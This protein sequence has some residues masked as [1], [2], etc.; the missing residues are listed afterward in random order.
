[1]EVYA[2]SL[3]VRSA[4]NE[5]LAAMVDYHVRRRRG[6]IRFAYP[7]VVLDKT[8]AAAR[9]I[10]LLLAGP[11]CQGHSNLNNHT[12]RNDPRNDLYVTTAATAVA[13]AARGV[14]IENVATV[15][16]SHGDVVEIARELLLQ[17]GYG[18]ADGRLKLSDLGG[19]QTRERYFMIAVGGVSSENLQK[20]FDRWVEAHRREAL[21]V[22]WAID[23]LEEIAN[24]TLDTN[25]NSSPQPKKETRRRIDWLFDNEAHDLA[26]A[27]R[28]DCHKEGTTYTAVYG[29]MHEKKPAPTITTGIGTPGQGRFIHPRARRLITP[30][31]A[32][33]IQTFPDWW[34]FETES[35]RP[36][37]TALAKWIGDA[38][39]PM[40]GIHPITVALS[41]ILNEKPKLP[42]ND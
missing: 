5:S 17:S 35:R 20:R 7:P 42:W 6:E 29:R 16:R 28:P 37:R 26:L 11:P 9:G 12:R 30:H 41:T 18:V 4:V 21:P 34:K 23:D 27:E 31:E 8:L 25:F 10:D 36:P 32:A 13:L 40:L 22:T 2:H 33:R 14:V 38:V 39:P 24:Q 15:V 19:P 1:M 3:P